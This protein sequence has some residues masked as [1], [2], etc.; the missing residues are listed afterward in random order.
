MEAKH[1]EELS[2]LMLA[3]QVVTKLGYTHSRIMKEDGT[4]NYPTLRNIR[5]GRPIKGSTE[6]YYLRL[7]VSI[8]NAEF[9]QRLRNGGDGANELLIV[10]KNILLADLQIK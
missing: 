3:Y 4:V 1:R 9:E 5:E 8:I 2:A 6:R 7:F 10:M